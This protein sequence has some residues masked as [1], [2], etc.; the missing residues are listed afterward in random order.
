MLLIILRIPGFTQR[1]QFLEPG[2]KSSVWGAPAQFHLEL[3]LL[4]CVHNT[5]FHFREQQIL[6]ILFPTE[7]HRNRAQGQA[8][9]SWL[10]ESGPGNEAAHE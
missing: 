9:P 4:L 8:A 7:R 3:E 5:R 2:G 6:H 1:L 10:C